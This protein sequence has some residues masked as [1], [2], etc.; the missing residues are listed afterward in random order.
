MF[1]ILILTESINNKYTKMKKIVFLMIAFFQI[2]SIAQIKYYQKLFDDSFTMEHSVNCDQLIIWSDG[3]EK[4]EALLLMYDATQDV[5]YLQIFVQYAKNVIDRRDDLRDSIPPLESLGHPYYN[6]L[7]GEKITNFLNVISPTWSSNYYNTT[8]S[9]SPYPNLYRNYL[10]LYPLIKFYNLI[11]ANVALQS[12]DVNSTDTVA[13]Y[14]YQYMFPPV[15]NFNYVAEQFLQRV[16]ETINFYNNHV[17][18]NNVGLWSTNIGAY[19]EFNFNFASYPNA[20]LPMNMQASIGRTLLE[21]Y[22][23]TND[24]FYLE[25][26]RSIGAYIKLKTSINTVTN[27]KT[28]HYWGGPDPDV[29]A[30]TTVKPLREDV[31]HSA[32]T[33]LFPLECYKSGITLVN[34]NSELM[35][36]Y[37]DVLQYAN[38]FTKDIYQ[39]VLILKEGVTNSNTDPLW[40]F[41]FKENVNLVSNTVITN[42]SLYTY[43]DWIAYSEIDAKIYQMVSDFNT[44]IHYQS[45]NMGSSSYLKSLI[46]LAYLA[47]YDQKFVPIAAEHS[48]GTESNWAGISKGNFDGDIDDGDEFVFLR[49]F[50]NKIMIQNKK[51]N[52]GSL[53]TTIPSLEPNSGAGLFLDNVDHDYKWAGVTAGDFYGDG[54]SEIIALSN[55]TTAGR[56]GFYTFNVN[57]ISGSGN[58]INFEETKSG[59]GFSVLS[60]W[61]GITSGDFIGDIYNKDDFIMVRNQDKKL[62]IY[63][64]N[65]SNLQQV[66]SI[67]LNHISLGAGKIGTTSNIKAIA[68]GNLD[69]NS[70]NGDELAVLVDGSSSNYSGLYIYQINNTGQ[71]GLI[72]KSVGWGTGSNFKGLAV[73]D[74]DYNG[75]DE[76]VIHRNFDAHYSVYELDEFNTNL[77][78]IGAEF[79]DTRQTENNILCAGNFEAVCKND[80]LISLRNTDAGII[81]Y[82]N[83]LCDNGIAS[84]RA[85]GFDLAQETEKRMNELDHVK[86]YPNPAN[87]Y[88]T[89]ISS[90]QSFNEVRITS[91][92]GR[93]VFDKKTENTNKVELDISNFI[94][95]I[96][97]VSIVKTDGTMIIEKV[98]KNY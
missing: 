63:K 87:S 95:G 50:D 85:I 4:M 38:T 14:N 98:F 75:K 73:G 32:V 19:K 64:S 20:I 92:D 29:V 7:C 62:Y 91:M 43:G 10:V 24:N 48:W 6:Q 58:T 16:T 49:N 41:D 52:E 17:D 78:S 69:G 60:N 11:K 89:I 1:E 90:N 21:F 33:A 53:E 31:S 81:M 88:L 15:R 77:V 22:K 56:N 28:W 46:V 40:I 59:L 67:S 71:I 96:Y 80:E 18:S 57:N 54:K 97:T 79:F 83:Y 72:V 68:S 44:S 65:G 13:L 42:K 94:V 25:R 8:G 35:F 34:G 86:I 37:N 84:G 23:A 82:S 61:A 27:S 47:K 45:P 30:G 74:F 93:L 51:L 2:Q 9:A 76:V 26:V 12:I 55:C 3:V 66:T 70:L 36:K 39:D 5:K